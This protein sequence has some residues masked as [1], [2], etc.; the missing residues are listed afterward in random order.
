[1]RSLNAANARVARTLSR[2]GLVKICGLGQPEHAAAAAQAGADLIG[3]IFAPARRF[4]PPEEASACIEAARSVNDDIVAVGVFVDATTEEI[5]SAVATAGID[6]VQLHGAEAPELVASL[7]VPAIKVFRP[8]PGARAE[9]VAAE[10]D[11][12]PSGGQTR[13]WFL[14]DGY[15]EHAAGGTGA[16]ADWRLA[17]EI[18][19]RTPVFLGGGLDGENIATAIHDVRP[20]GVDVSSGVER[21]GVKDAARI[22][23]FV[24]AAKAAFRQ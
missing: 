5:A 23:A 11:R 7:P 4:I 24:A 14:L 12:Y 21:N 15:A 17:A 22:A 2:R 16:R 13:T 1:M 9:L 6:M 20:I 19:R 8:K 3:F 18:A 10:I